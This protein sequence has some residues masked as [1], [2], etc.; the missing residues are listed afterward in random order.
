MSKGT[1]L[2]VGGFELPDKNAAAHRPVENA[3]IFTELGYQTVIIG[4]HKNMNLEVLKG[5]VQSGDEYLNTWSIPYPNS[6]LDRIM[7]I[8]SAKNFIKIIKN[9]QDV[10]HVICYNYQSVAFLKII[11]YCNKKS[12]KIISDCTEWYSSKE[13]NVIFRIIKYIDT[14]FRMRVIN[15]RA[16]GLIVASNFLKHYYVKKNIVKIPMLFSKKDELIYNKN[17]FLK[18]RSFI[19]AGIPFKLG[20]ELKN[21]KNAKDRLDIVLSLFRELKLRNHEFVFHIYGLTKEEYLKVIPTDCEII[22]D[23]GNNVVFHGKV[24]NVQLREAISEADFSI[25]IRDE[26]RVTKAGFPTKFSESIT[27]GTPVIT[28]RVGDVAEYLIEGENGY[29]I[30]HIDFDKAIDKLE[31]ILNIKLEEIVT[32]KKKC[33]EFNKFRPESWK[34]DIEMFFEKLE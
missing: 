16:D 3:K 9:Y 25:L 17:K 19:Y 21:K 32:M 33:L 29:F 23:L 15:K 31:A 5:K 4:I 12:I 30:N 26:N 14:S 13:G 6:I 1:I 18:K 28:N 10:S 8:S 24:E 34:R 27:Y 2:Y 22:S 20:K 11:N 7:F